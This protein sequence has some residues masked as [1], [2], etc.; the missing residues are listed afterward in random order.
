M[1]MV[2]VLLT[3]LLGASSVL[4]DGA[5]IVDAISG[6]QNATA[7]LTSTVASWDGGILGAL[8]L[9]SES[10]SLLTAINDAT[11]TTKQSANLTDIEAVTVGITILSLVTDVNSSLT[12]II[13]AKPKFD[14]VFSSGIVLLN[15][16]LE[17]SA[18]ADFS[19]ASLE[20]LPATFASVGETLSGEITDSFDQAIGVHNG[21]F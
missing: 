8:P 15:L 4:A 13:D 14:K 17:R 6:I 5:A 19:D 3:T 12:T 11:D 18:S 1:M 20:K 2:K 10:T 7:E 9:V 21:P 16:A